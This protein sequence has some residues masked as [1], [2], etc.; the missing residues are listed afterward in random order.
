[1]V[2]YPLPMKYMDHV[3]P[4]FVNSLI[5]DEIMNTAI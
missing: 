3:T 5:D 1:M 4:L 2:I